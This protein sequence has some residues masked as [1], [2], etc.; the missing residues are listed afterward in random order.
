MVWI[1]DSEPTCVSDKQSFW[2]VSRFMHDILYGVH[3]V[4]KGLARN[5]DVLEIA[6][7]LQEEAPAAATH[8]QSEPEK[9][10]PLQ[11]LLHVSNLSVVLPASSM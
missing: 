10:Q 6:T 4:T 8:E 1:I 11:L 2:C 3:I 7:G 9:A 5:A